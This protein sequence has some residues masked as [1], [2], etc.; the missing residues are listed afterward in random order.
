MLRP[1]VDSPPSYAVLVSAPGDAVTLDAL[2]TSPQCLIR[3]QQNVFALPQFTP[4]KASG[5]A[6]AKPLENTVPRADKY[7]KRC[8][9]SQD[10]ARLPPRPPHGEI[11]LFLADLASLLRGTCFAVSP[12]GPPLLHSI[13]RLFLCFR[14]R[15]TFQ[16]SIVRS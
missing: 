13:S 3:S 15:K 10:L 14:L 6:S 9:L 2:Q 12:F 8:K 1:A 4:I 5:F 7:A 16:P 11:V